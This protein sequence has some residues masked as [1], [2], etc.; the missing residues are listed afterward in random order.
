M[1]ETLGQRL[2]AMR[3]E[4]GLRL[5]DVA[6]AAGISI[7]WLNDMEHDRNTPS[8]DTLVRLATAFGTTAAELLRGV[9]P[10]GA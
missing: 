9:P 10:Y 5:A 3:R 4:R 2:I 6:D 7:S 8:L 1:D